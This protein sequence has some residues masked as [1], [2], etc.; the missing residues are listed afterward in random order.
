MYYVIDYLTN[1]SVPDPEEGP[2]LE[3][4]EEDVDVPGADA[5][6]TGEPFEGVIATPIKIEATPHHGYSG[7]PQDFF[8][9]AIAFMSPRLEKV[10]KD[11]GVDNLDL[12]PALI[13]YRTTGEVHEVLAFNLIGLVSAVDYAGSDLESKDGDFR[14]DTSLLGLEVDL[15]KTRDLSLFRLAEN[16]MTVLAHERIKKAVDAAGINT[17]TFVEA[18]DWTQL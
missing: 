17:F 2:F 14:M 1:P 11:Q 15:S 16:C 9:G 8:D 4:H 18:K 10:L 5:W 13:T 7:P 3:I 6:Q 12:Y